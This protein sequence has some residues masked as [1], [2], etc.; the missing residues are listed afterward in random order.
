[1]IDSKTK[2]AIEALVKD[3]EDNEKALSAI[4]EPPKLDKAAPLPADATKVIALTREK[5]GK[6]VKEYATMYSELEKLDAE[7]QSALAAAL[8]QCKAGAEKATKAYLDAIKNTDGLTSA[9]PS[10][11]KV[12]QATGK[13]PDPEAIRAAVEG[14]GKHREE[15]AKQYGKDKDKAKM[16]A[17]FN[18]DL[19]AAAKAL[20]GL[21]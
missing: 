12:L 18:K 8:A 9:K 4:P 19:D 3:L 11:V 14:L 20:G 21:L 1:M 16:L 2:A 6:A 5:V 17:A 7:L 15:M 10:I 13:M